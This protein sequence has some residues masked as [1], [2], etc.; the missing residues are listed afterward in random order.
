LC[1][2]PEKAIHQLRR[3]AELGLPNYLLFIRD[4]LLRTIQDEP[5]FTSLMSDLRRQY[6]QYHQEF[7]FIRE[8]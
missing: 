7:G 2:K 1:G 3:C 6:D 8:N 5:G 4:P